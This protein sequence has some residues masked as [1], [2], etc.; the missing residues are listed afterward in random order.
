MVRR[1]TEEVVGK[2]EEFGGEET[3]CVAGMAGKKGKKGRE[4]KEEYGW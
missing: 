3:D 4:G 1:G 2:E